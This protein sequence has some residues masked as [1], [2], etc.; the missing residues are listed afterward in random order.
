MKKGLLFLFIFIFLYPVF[1][2]NLPIP[3]DRVLQILGF[4]ILLF[5][6]QDVKR[7]LKSKTVW[8][9]F[10][11]TFILLLL[12]IFAQFQLTSGLDLFFVKE[13]FNTYLYV[14]SVYLICWQMKKAYSYISF[15]I[16]IYY[17]SLAAI[18][19]TFISFLFFFNNELFD[20]YISFLKV[21]TNQGLL[22]RVS[23]INKRFIGF[24]SNFFMGV[25]K[26][27]IAFFSI[28]ILPLVYK[29]WLTK[30]KLIYKVSVLLVATGGILTG[31]TFFAAIILGIILITLIKSKSI[32][33]F[34]FNNLKALFTVSL[35]LVLLFF[36]AN[37]VFEPDRF[38]IVY[39]FVFELLI[40]FLE[41]DSLESGTTTRMAEMY[42]FPENIK[43]WF[44]GDGKLTGEFGGYYMRTDIGY[45]R[46]LFYFGLPSTLYFIFLLFKYYT[47]LNKL[48]QLKATNY[49]LFF[50]TLWILLLNFKGLTF[51]SKY[52]VLFLLILIFQ[53]SQ[54]SL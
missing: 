24:G 15:G 25:I 40:N 49:F 1:P 22:S 37:K 31:R 16:L 51:S 19:Q 34:I 21:E 38:Q 35:S 47:L 27:G 41:N 45:I 13:V 2:K 20:A 39:S 4:T 8:L 7:I 30:Y 44:L 52:F 33:S 10:S 23:S 17:I 53:K 14:F 42:F 18:F 3:L 5:N 54:R 48:V 11:L 28:L 32:S 26:Y 36:I 9:F 29:C 46:L 43:T 12:T 6:P 50:T